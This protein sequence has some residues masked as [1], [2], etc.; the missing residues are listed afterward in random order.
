[1]TSRSKSRSSSKDKTTRRAAAPIDSP[2]NSLTD[3]LLEF[4]HRSPTAHHVVATSV[5]RLLAAGFTWFDA[6]STLPTSSTGS[7]KGFVTRDGALIAF[8]IPRS[9]AKHFR[10]VGAHTDSPGLHL[11][12]NP[13]GLAAN[14]GT[15]EVEIYGSPLLNSW[16][17]RDLDVAGHV[18]HRD[19]TQR[20]FTSPSPVARLAQLAIHLDR[21]VNENGVV[22]DKH[23]HL[24][25][26]WHTGAAE[27]S[28]RELAAKWAGVAGRDVAA[29]HAQLVDHEPARVIGIDQSMV[30]GARLDNQ[31][32]CWAA[33]EAMADPSTNISTATNKKAAIAVVALFDH[34]EVGSESTTGAAGPLLE[35]MLER[36]ALSLGRSR[37]EYLAMLPG[38]LCLSCDNAHAVHPNYPE[39]HDPK[40]AP[41]INQ[42]V[43][44]KSNSNQRYATSASSSVAFTAACAAAKVNHQM[45]VSR[46]SMPCGSTIGPITAT[47]LGIDTVDVG[48]PQLSMHSAREVCGVRDALDLPCIAREFLRG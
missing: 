12:P 11:K 3:S 43:V 46:N 38:S 35:H 19:G 18:V 37:N 25:P 8:V 26:V 42:G 23:A 32:S 39:R 14:F 28:I 1:M 33:I 17:D 47:R 48:V 10:I 16:L 34:E 9:T 21:G 27:S 4:L 13:E 7:V 29:V 30:A 31:L 44:L 6:A 20:L 24:R 45:F 2:N 15:L 41:F 36:I 40:H 22:L 5:Q